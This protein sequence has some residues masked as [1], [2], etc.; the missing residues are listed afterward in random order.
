MEE[1]P[2]DRTRMGRRRKGRKSEHVFGAESRSSYIHGQPHESP[3]YQIFYQDI[4]ASIDRDHL[5]EMQRTPG[6]LKAA[7]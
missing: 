1:S 5:S 6:L 7:P 2:N 4:E 3:I